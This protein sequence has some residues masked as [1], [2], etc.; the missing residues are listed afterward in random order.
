[1]EYPACARSGRRVGPAQEGAFARALRW[2]EDHRRLAAMD[3]RL[4]RDIGLT[5]EDLCRGRPFGLPGSSCPATPTTASAGLSDHRG[6]LVRLGL[7]QARGWQLKLYAPA[8]GAAGLCREDLAAA[9]RAF[10]AVLAEPR[11]EP[12]AGFAMLDSAPDM[13]S[14]S[15]SLVLTASWWEGAVLQRASLLLPGNEP[16]RRL[17]DHASSAAEVLLAAREC[18]AWHHHV[19]QASHPSFAAYLAEDCA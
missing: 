14:G 17:P 9:M 3:D 11:P 16:P 2:I 1:M 7:F 19:L 6:S 5:R 12:A 18:R 13:A 4:L 8:V 10:R 15:G